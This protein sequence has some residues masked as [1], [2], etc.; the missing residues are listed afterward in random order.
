[1]DCLNAGPKRKLFVR[2]YKRFGITQ[3]CARMGKLTPISRELIF[4]N[5]EITEQPSPIKREPVDFLNEK[6][7]DLQVRRIGKPS[8]KSIFNSGCFEVPK[9]RNMKPSHCSRFENLE[10]CNTKDRIGDALP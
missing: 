5:D 4:N 2:C 9:N 10:Q 1:M 7:K 8:R 6:N 3:R